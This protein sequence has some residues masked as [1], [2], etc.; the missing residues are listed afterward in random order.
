MI[1]SNARSKRVWVCLKKPGCKDQELSW[2][3]SVYQITIEQDSIFPF[4]SV[5]HSSPIGHVSS[6]P[7]TTQE[8][9]LRD[10]YSVENKKSVNS[11]TPNTESLPPAQ[12]ILFKSGSADHPPPKFRWRN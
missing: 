6:E 8:P 7:E 2:K 1:G 11:V 5:A 10:L 3:K 9:P 4:G 12:G